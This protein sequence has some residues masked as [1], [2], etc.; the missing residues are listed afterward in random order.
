MDIN[1]FKALLSRAGVVVRDQDLTKVFELM[2]LRQVGKV[3]Y[4]DF[5]DVIE[6][7]AQVPVEK[8]VRK[9]RIDRGETYIENPGEGLLSD[10]ISDIKLKT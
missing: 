1:E 10:Q 9:R 2:D 5:C 4:N 6:K 7:N 8:I 3:S